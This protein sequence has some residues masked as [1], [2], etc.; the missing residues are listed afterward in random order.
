MILAV[1]AVAISGCGNFEQPARPP[2]VPPAATWVGGA[3]GGAF[4][5]CMPS[6]HGQPNPCTVYN[7][8]GDIWMSGAFIMQETGRGAFNNELKYLSVDGSRIYLKDRRTL[9]PVFRGRPASVPGTAA[10]A[11]NGVYVNCIQHRDSVYQCSLF[12]AATGRVIAAGRY[13]CQTHRECW[14]RS[15]P[16]I[17]TTEVINLEGGDSLK[18]MSP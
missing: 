4:L 6:S 15:H 8:S 12:L 5:D 2:T 10:L 7:E 14:E 1:I 11:T 18:R 17:A 3:D 16:K 13:R 9:A